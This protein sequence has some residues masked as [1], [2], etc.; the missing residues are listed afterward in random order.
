MN[1]F[2]QEIF[3]L[4]NKPYVYSKENDITENSSLNLKKMMG[5]KENINLLTS[6][7]INELDLD[8]NLTTDSIRLKVKEYINS[9]INLGKF[10]DKN[11][12][13]KMIKDDLTTTLDY[14]NQMFIETFKESFSPVKN[15]YTEDINPFRVA[16]QGKMHKDMYVDDIR[17]L[18]VQSKQTAF[19]IH[20]QC[21]I[22]DNSIKYY[23]KLSRGRNYER[24]E[25]DGLNSSG[26]DK[27]NI[28]YK[29]YGEESFKELTKYDEHPSEFKHLPWS[30]T[31]YE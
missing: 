28:V 26:Y 25:T 6:M 18:D 14:I 19:N 3:N 17:S 20:D 22:R 21:L 11:I 4:N 23:N 15:F 27:E 2:R 31:Q 12:S 16:K 1:N 5:S 7:M 10:D 24:K 13:R 30:E 8:S 29:R 9:W